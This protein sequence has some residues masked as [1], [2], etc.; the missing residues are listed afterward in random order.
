M[1]AKTTAPGVVR[2]Q[3]KPGEALV[4]LADLKGAETMMGAAQC[5]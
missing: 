4:V 5:G 3:F 2:D 1:T